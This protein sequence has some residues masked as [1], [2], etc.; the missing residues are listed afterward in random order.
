VVQNI[1]QRNFELDHVVYIPAGRSFL[2]MM[3]QNI[4]TILRAD[5]ALDPVLLGFASLYER[6]R[7]HY[8]KYHRTFSELDNA[9]LKERYHK[10]LKGHYYHVDNEDRFYIGEKEYFFLSELSSGQQ[11]LLPALVVLWQIAR[12]DR[13]TT[14]VFEEPEAHLF[15]EDQQALLELLVHIV[16]ETKG[17]RFIITTHS[18]YLLTTMN[19]FFY[20]HDL[21]KNDEGVVREIV[22]INLWCDFEETTAMAMKKDTA[23]RDLLDRSCRL[24]DAAYLDEASGKS[25]AIF[26]RLLSLEARNSDV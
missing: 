6:V 19:N 21:G 22:P 11:E 18:P 4:F 25:A 9:F 24:I 1:I 5:I 16:N 14:I 10:L 3:T 23:C 26:D 12:S 8:G 7:K 15:P 2:T 17:S 13:P 20:A